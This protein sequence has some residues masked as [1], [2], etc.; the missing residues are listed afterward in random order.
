MTA[1]RSVACFTCDN[2]GEAADVAALIQ[3]AAELR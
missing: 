1:P 3:V 2:M